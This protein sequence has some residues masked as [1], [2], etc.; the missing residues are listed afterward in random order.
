MLRC[1]YYFVKMYLYYYNHYI[2]LTYK[3]ITLVQKYL[4]QILEKIIS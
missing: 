2:L 3:L 1:Y 4:L